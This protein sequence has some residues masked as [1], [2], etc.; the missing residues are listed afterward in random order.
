MSARYLVQSRLAHVVASDAHSC[1]RPPA[2]AVGMDRLIAGGSTFA[3]AR[4]LVE[5]NPRELVTAGIV[6]QL[7]AAA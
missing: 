6:R 2:L 1:A 7:A 4:R 3:A 5:L